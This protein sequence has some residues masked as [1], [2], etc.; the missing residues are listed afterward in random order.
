MGYSFPMK[1]WI[2]Y[3]LAGALGYLYA[4]F[5]P[6]FRDHIEWVDAASGII[7][8]VVPWVLYP[9]IFFSLSGAVCSVR[10]QKLKRRVLS[11]VTGWIL[12]THTALAVLGTMIAAQVGASPEIALS[13]V[14]KDPLNSVA[15]LQEA[16]TLRRL[17]FWLVPAGAVIFGLALRPESEVHR[18]MYSYSGLFLNISRCASQ[19]LSLGAVAF[20]GQLFYQLQGTQIATRAQALL[21]V[22]FLTTLIGVLLLIPLIALILSPGRHPYGKLAALAAPYLLALT[23]GSYLTAL[24]PL[25]SHGKSNIGSTPT[26]TAVSL[27]VHA[28]LGRGGTAMTAGMLAV[29]ALSARGGTPLP[30]LTI[31][32]IAGAAVL[33]SCAAF[34]APGMELPFTLLLVTSLVE[35]DVQTGI[36][37]AAG[38]ILLQGAAASLDIIISGMGTAYTA[39]RLGSETP[40][41]WQDMQ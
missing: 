40:V 34:L 6:F 2:K 3:L 13:V 23:S 15:G 1:L 9:L 21:L 14:P 35:I 20:S 17:P 33:C 37:I 25:Y 22:T 28:V 18:H 31:L 11:P 10:G 24:V 36:I 12:L 7:L 39:R 27:P 26:V 16:L 32:I 29:T 19:W 30:L 38:S 8:L 5:I 41:R 4:V